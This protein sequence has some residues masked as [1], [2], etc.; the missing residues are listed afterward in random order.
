MFGRASDTADAESSGTL[1]IERRSV[2]QADPTV[3]QPVA[4]SPTRRAAASR[5][6]RLSQ[7]CPPRSPSGTLLDRGVDADAA[8][9]SMLRA[10]RGADPP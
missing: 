8:M 3:W 7:L 10:Y 1:P 2:C 5:A 6:L 9:P 4:M